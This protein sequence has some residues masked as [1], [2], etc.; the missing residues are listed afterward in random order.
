MKENR[1]KERPGIEKIE[2]PTTKELNEGNS[3]APDRHQV[4]E[5]G[6]GQRDSGDVVPRN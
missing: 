1:E 3:Q 4:G 6:A 2:D 5:E